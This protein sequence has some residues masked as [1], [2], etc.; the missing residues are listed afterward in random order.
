MTES[1]S[2]FAAAVYRAKIEIK[3]VQATQI[4]K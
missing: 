4:Q 3:A 1:I 2:K